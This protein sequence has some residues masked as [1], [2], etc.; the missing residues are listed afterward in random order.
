MRGG[1]DAEDLTQAFFVHLIERG[2]LGAERERGRFRNWLLGA[3][4]HFLADAVEAAHAAKRGG[5]IAHVALDDGPL[6]IADPGDAPDRAFERA[7]AFTVIERAM[8]ALRAEAE[9]RGKGEQ[10]ALL[11]DIVVEPRDTGALKALA[12]DL[13]VRANTLAVAVKRYRTRLQ[14]LVR[15]EVAQTVGDPRLIDAVMQAFR[16]SLRC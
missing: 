15:E 14:E 9:A 12:A 13:G 5:S 8:A 2:R 1:L 3:L 7:F 16:A 4:K 10:L 11:A 6:P